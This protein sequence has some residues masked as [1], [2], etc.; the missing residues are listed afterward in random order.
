MTTGGS[1]TRDDIRELPAAAWFLLAGTLVNR[2]GSF[3]LAFLVLYLT[4]R[5][6][7]APEAGLAVSAYGIGSVAASLAGGYLADRIG[8][9]ST[10]A[11]SM[12]LS[13]AAMI[14]LWRASTMSAI[15]PLTGVAGF[16]SELYRPAS[17]AL[18]T[19]LTEPGKRVTAFALYRLAINLGMGIGPAV[20]GVM[21]E[22]SFAWL[23]IGDAATSVVFGLLALVALPAGIKHAGAKP[24][25]KASVRL[26]MSDKGFLLFLFASFLGMLVY[27]QAHS[28]F[29]LHVVAHGFSNTVYGLLLSLNGLMVVVIELPLSA[30]T[31]RFEPKKVMAAGMLLTGIGFGLTGLA[32][33]L[34]FLVATVVIWTL[35]EIIA[36]PVAA[37]YVAD[38][39]PDHMRG[40]YQ[41]SW[42]LSFG[43][44]FM[45]GPALGT[46][47][48]HQFSS[49]MWLGCFVV[50][51]TAAAII[52]VARPKV[53]SAATKRG[54]SGEEGNRDV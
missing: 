26:L 23:F 9:R 22:R 33:P 54:T 51:A 4:R 46:M 47:L 53:H 48:W 50:N 28:T 11:I 18:L 45:F 40:L 41:G 27:V 16:T 19:D 42:G 25:P 12:F 2:F 24:H 35:G 3:V 43:F 21:A 31:R 29:P 6:Y 32:E 13:A 14:A 1:S 20:G 38:N 36:M 10:I 44:G 52:L 49:L 34:Y 39:S 15:I 37:A 8:R 5:G 7:S 17:A 30:V